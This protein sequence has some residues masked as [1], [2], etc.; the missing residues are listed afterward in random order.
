MDPP[1]VRPSGPEGFLVGFVEPR[2]ALVLGMTGDPY[3]VA[4]EIRRREI[5]K[6]FQFRPGF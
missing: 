3:G 6:L 5:T 1:A 2:F 4:I